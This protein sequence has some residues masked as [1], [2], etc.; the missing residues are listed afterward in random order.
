MWQG[1]TFW[2]IINISVDDKV[3]CQSFPKKLSKTV[4]LIQEVVL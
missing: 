4:E 1:D 2:Y 3:Y